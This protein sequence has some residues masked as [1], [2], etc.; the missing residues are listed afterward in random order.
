MSTPIRNILILGPQGSGK[1][2][3][4]SLLAG[5]FKLAHIETGKIFRSMAKGQTALGRRIHYLVNTKGSLIPDALVIRILE[6]AL[7]RVKK[8]QGIV[9]DGFPRTITQAR[10][11][12]RLFN[13]FGRRLTTVIDMPISRA[14]TVRRLSLRRTCVEC[15][16][17]FI[18]GVNVPL[19]GTVCPSCGGQIIQREDDKPQAIA[20]RLAS[21][22]R[23][24]KPVILYY[25]K[26]GILVRVDGEPPV[27]AVFKNILK[28]FSAH[29]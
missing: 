24:T 12:T 21:Y 10:A 1:G 19:K 18:A 13:K 11:L 28:L 9:F 4:A 26:M 14:T 2:T 3:Q 20:R 27:K 6:K 22:T 15:N 23:L 17:I 7:R 5:R 16:R 25:K 8:T 29:D